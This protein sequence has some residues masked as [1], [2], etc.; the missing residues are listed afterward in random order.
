MM[1][2]IDAFAGIRSTTLALL[3]A[4][5]A[6]ACSLGEEITDVVGTDEEARH[7]SA[8]AVASAGSDPPPFIDASLRNGDLGG[9]VTDIPPVGGLMDTPD[10]VRFVANAS[11]GR[12]HG[13]VS[14]NIPAQNVSKADLRRSGTVSF[15]IYV[16]SDS[17][18]AGELVS[19]NFGFGTFNNGQS[20]FSLGMLGIGPGGVGF[21]TAA[22]LSGFWDVND[23]PEV[24][25]TE[26][27]HSVGFSWGAGDF[28]YEV[29]VDG[30]VVNSYDTPSGHSL[31]WGRSSSA[32]QFGLGYH[33]QRGLRPA[34]SVV[35]VMV[36]EFRV[37]KDPV[38]ACGTEVVVPPNSPPEAVDDDAETTPPRPIDIDV[39]ANDSDPDGDV[40]G[41][42]AVTRSS[43]TAATV[44]INSDGTVR[45]APVDIDHIASR[46][47]GLSGLNRGQARSLLVKLEVAQR[48][49][50]RGRSEAAAGL[51]GAFLNQIQAFE[52][53]GKLDSTTA[54]E[55]ISL[56]REIIDPPS[57]DS[58][59]YTISDGELTADATVTV[60]LRS[61]ADAE[62]DEDDDETG[63]DRNENREDSK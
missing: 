22:W 19:E 60:T 16:D 45:Y 47:R 48:S 30:A 11:N 9:G 1:V 25:A 38:P 44:S 24:I 52:R 3:A 29:C 32:E 56:V 43:T 4:V 57:T 54:A 28:D 13:I 51:L 40:I 39:L 41:V 31:P 15:M 5:V 55:L 53:A 59:T 6:G 14:W 33:H 58:F 8:A 63:G 18:V 49:Y 23:T 26:R 61:L 42:V 36:A 17:Y 46:V 21:R 50:E 10:G 62:D 37:W 27:W 2:R 12:S 34:G 35:G 20:T 7:A